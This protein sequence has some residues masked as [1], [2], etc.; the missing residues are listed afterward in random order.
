MSLGTLNRHLILEESTRV[1]DGAGGY[2]DA[3]LAVG[4][5]WASVIAGSGREALG[6][7]VALSSVPYKIKIRS[8][9]V[10][11]PQRPRADQRF[12]ERSR[13]YRILSVADADEGQ[14]YLMCHCV[15]EAAG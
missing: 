15:E 13:I 9:P 6:G 8:A 3:W 2:T 4:D 10:G 1:S 14:R 5:L 7:D 12:R 11:S